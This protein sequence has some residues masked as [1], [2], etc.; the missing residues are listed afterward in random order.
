MKILNRARMTWAIM[1]T[2]ARVADGL[3]IVGLIAATAWLF[4]K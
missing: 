2:W 3:I 1:P 4:W